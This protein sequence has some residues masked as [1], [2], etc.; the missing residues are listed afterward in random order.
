MSLL[1]R[2]LLPLLTLTLVTTV[3]P[4][5]RP[6]RAEALTTCP[7]YPLDVGVVDHPLW[8]YEWT[9]NEVVPSAL[10]DV[11]QKLQD[12]CV[13]WLRVDLGW[14]TMTYGN[15]TSAWLPYQTFSNRNVPPDDYYYKVRFETLLAEL[16]RRGIKELVTVWATPWW[17]TTATSDDPITGE[18]NNAR[19]VQARSTPPADAATYG[20]F[21]KDFLIPNYSRGAADL[22]PDLPH[23]V[24]AW[25]IWN[26]PNLD[27]FLYPSEIEK[28]FPLLK[29]AYTAFSD[30]NKHNETV[31]LGGPAQNDTDWLS[32]LY[33]WQQTR[34]CT[35]AAGNLHSCFDVLSTHPYM[36]PRDTSPEYPASNEK[37]LLSHTGKVRSL[38]V[39]WG[40]GSMPIWFTEFGWSSHYPNTDPP[41]DPTTQ[42]DFD[43]TW[44]GTTPE[45]QADY[46]VRAL[47][48]IVNKNNSQTLAWDVQNVFWYEARN[49][50]TPPNPTPYELNEAHFGLLTRGRVPKLAYEA[51][52]KHL[53]P[54]TATLS[55]DDPTPEYSLVHL[56]PIPGA[57]NIIDNESDELDADEGQMPA[58]VDD[59]VL[60]GNV[61]QWAADTGDA[62]ASQAASYSVSM[63]AVR[64]VTERDFCRANATFSVTV[65]KSDDNPVILRYSTAKDASADAVLALS[66]CDYDVTKGQ[67]EFRTSGET[68]YI[69]VPISPYGDAP[70][71][72]GD[73]RG[74]HEPD[75][76]F[77][78]K[79]LSQAGTL[80]ASGKV[81]IQDDE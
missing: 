40:D 31:V 32:E 36:A 46:L 17:A 66:W 25:E 62:A 69:R 13:K 49:Q 3:L 65:T 70:K 80:R 75:Q 18:D 34:R 72:D 38:M 53:D 67:L 23:Y 79:V 63:T 56:D 59:S 43:A 33:A 76:T 8:D 30:A 35:D 51:L 68:K 42:T 41:D 52:R 9:N 12:A 27:G 24:E 54:A 28:Y 48:Y 50:A 71:C 60:T 22:N 26:E 44:C 77:V 4:V 11:L 64:T 73:A 14:A 19:D 61:S 39:K 20:D 5:I 58:P 16:Y 45:Q 29:E 2:C 21:F 81:V 78:V 1:R 57:D 55:W 47:K 74:A 15:A 10:M 7:P 37:W 6:D